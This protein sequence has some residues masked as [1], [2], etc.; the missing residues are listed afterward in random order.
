MKIAIVGTGIA[1]LSAGWLLQ[2]AGHQPV[3]LERNSSLGMDANSFDF[4]AAE[5]DDANSDQICRVDLPLRMFNRSM[6]PN[7]ANLYNTIGVE[8][9][10]VDPSK[11]FS[12]FDGRADV[13]LGA[14]YSASLPLKMLLNGTARKVGVGIRQM[15]EEVPAALAGDD[16]AG[17]DFYSYLKRQ[18]YSDVFIYKFL[19]PSLASTVCTCSYESLKRYPAKTVLT[20]MQLLVDQPQLLRTKHGAQDV[21]QR[22]TTDIEDIRLDS[23]VTAVE[24][25]ENQ[26]RIEIAD[27][28]PIVVDHLIIA[29]QA[30]SAS[31][32]LSDISQME[33]AMLDCFTYENIDVVVHRDSSLMPPD[34]ADW[35]HFNL[36]SESDN[37][38]AM[39]SVWMNR[40][41]P[42]WDIETPIFQTIGP[43]KGPAPDL[44][45]RQSHLQRPIVNE[46]SIHGLQLLDDLHN[47]T[48]RR[49]WFAGSYASPGV[50]LLESGVVS[51]MNVVRSL[52][53][54]LP[55]TMG[56][57]VG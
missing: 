17:V 27:Q 29:T 4:S 34:R 22:L 44:V 3:L 51:S 25:L 18:N 19:F 50:P 13:T 24:L 47:D 11:S 7:L 49:I 1:G 41:C 16:L 39:C 32:I 36:I 5:L 26:V 37:S 9:E 8:S 46:S 28:E 54:K 14:S 35:R 31:K 23:T 57:S 2:Q 48:D 38:A 33:R 56:S 43:I 15:M 21:V 10:P 45:L 42:D 12:D 20:A 52:Q 40:F 55:V 53:V 30:N 6:W